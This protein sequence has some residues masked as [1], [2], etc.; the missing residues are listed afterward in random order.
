MDFEFL[1]H[2]EALSVFKSPRPSHTLDELEKLA[3]RERLMKET[4]DYP[5]GY[6]FRFE[7]HNTL[8]FEDVGSQPITGVFEEDGGDF[9][10]TAPNED[11][12]AP[13]PII[14][15]PIESNPWENE[16]FESTVKADDDEEM[17]KLSR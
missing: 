10:D 14:S 7:T 12:N 13:R 2:D 15:V 3:V 4:G 8:S 16:V 1:N 6:P 11:P 5:P 9:A 17:E